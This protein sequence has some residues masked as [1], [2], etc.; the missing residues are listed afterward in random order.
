MRRDIL[1]QLRKNGLRRF[2]VHMPT[3]AGKTRTTI[4]SLVDFARSQYQPDYCIIWLAHS[5]ELC[6][7]ACEAMQ[8]VWRTRGSESLEILKLWGGRKLPSAISNGPKFVVTSFQTAYNYLHTSDD[9]RF[10]EY[11]SLRSKCALLVVDEAHQSIAP[12]YKQAIE[13]FANPKTKTIGLTATPG[14][15]GIGQQVFQTD[16]LS[17]FFQKTKV[18]MKS[19]EGLT[20]E[21]PLSY[22]TQK[23]ILSKVERF[24]LNSKEDFELSSRELEHIHN[25]LDIPR[26]VLNRIGNNAARTNLVA[27]YTAQAVVEEK[28]SVL[29][30]A[31]SKDCATELASL[32][33]YKNVEAAAITGETSE[34][35]RKTAIESFKKGNLSVLVNFGVLTTGFDAPNVD[36]VIVARPTTSVVLYSQMIGRGLRGPAMG[37]T[38]KCKIIDVFDNIKNMPCSSDAFAF[39]DGYYG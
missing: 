8:R 19:D 29:I 6:D 36:T 34:Y 18:S 27:S 7:Q 21:D 39:F 10:S 23:G 11:L 25:H 24:Q 35:S 30:F 15:H 33:T 13:L 28:A 14:R 4:E 31:P 2:L 26:S 3:G 37:G 16:E 20:L 5:E 12:T 9:T 32:L 17:D 38:E 22:L 1:S